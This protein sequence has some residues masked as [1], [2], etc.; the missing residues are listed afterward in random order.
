ML[1]NQEV[2]KLQEIVFNQK[3]SSHL[4]EVLKSTWE[5]VVTM[6]QPNYFDTHRNVDW[7]NTHT[8]HSKHERYSR[9]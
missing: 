3:S 8:Q 7:P 9:S 6:T 2:L 1:S 4:I 5:Q